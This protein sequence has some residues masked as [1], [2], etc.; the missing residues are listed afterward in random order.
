MPLPI[1]SFSD[2]F[3]L[4]I[5]KFHSNLPAVDPNQNASLARA[6]AASQSVAGYSLQDGLQDA[7]KQMFPQ[8]AD[9]DFLDLIGS[10]D[11]TIR[12][13]SVAAA[14]QAAVNGI[15]N[16]LIPAGTQLQY[17]SIIYLTQA[18]V[19]I[20]SFSDTIN[21]TYLNGT[22]TATTNLPH[23]LATGLSVLISGA[24]QSALNGTFTITVIGPNQFTYQVPAGVYVLDSGSYTSLS[25]L[26]NL[27]ATT[28]GENTNANAGSALNIAVTNVNAS[29]F[30]CFEGL[31]GGSDAET[32]DAYRARVMQAHSLT[33]GIATPPQEIWSAKKIS[34][35]TR[36]F[37]IRAQSPAN[38]GGR[39]TPGQAG[40]IPNVGETVI[41]IVR[42]NDLNIVPNSTLLAETKAQIIAD[43]LWPSFVSTD[44][45]YVLGPNL[46]A[47]N[48]TISNLSP[49]TLTM[50]NAIKNQLVQFFIENAFMTQPTKN[51]S[52]KA[53]IAFLNKVQDPTNGALIQS[54]TLVTPTADIAV[55][56]GQLAVLGAI[57]W[58]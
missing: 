17:G 31:A 7:V 55:G 4:V 43:G 20:Q 12:Y 45:L 47:V 3:N 30:V 19:Y 51:I 16:T 27:V 33:P 22:I 15:L 23:S 8:T 32:D 21:L 37:V 57:T 24:S 26:M 13:Q 1:R 35:N 2:F 25:A 18:D 6:L 5:G 11:K 14:G 28:E 50:Q 46:L 10:Y 34:G 56:S 42:D 54:Y 49:N 38:G 36:V 48:M 9:N 40:Y 53:L 41:Y 58:L 52:Y 39:G 29:A 44:Q